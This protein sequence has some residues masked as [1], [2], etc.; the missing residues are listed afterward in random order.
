MG[1]R[2]S[3]CDRTPVRPRTRGKWLCLGIAR[4]VGVFD[5]QTVSE[6]RRSITHCG[7]LGRTATAFER[8]TDYSRF[9][10]DIGPDMWN[11][12]SRGPAVRYAG[13]VDRAA[14]RRRR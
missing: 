8:P 11:A 1:V 13:D 14:L 9:R 3:P 2:S 10:P 12:D 5:R 6:E 4:R 7:Q